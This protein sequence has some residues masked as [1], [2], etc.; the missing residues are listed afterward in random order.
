MK[1][2]EAYKRYLKVVNILKEE[3]K[4]KILKLVHELVNKSVNY[5]DYVVRA[6]IRIEQIKYRLEGE[7]FRRELENIDKN[8]RLLHNALMSQLMIVNRTL[9]KDGDI[10][11]KIP[12]GGMFSGNVDALARKDRDAV[13][14]WAG[15]L[16]KGL[17]KH[18][19]LRD[20]KITY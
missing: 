16:V 2:E 11:D 9:F 17:R 6:E 19:I 12:I 7:D 3:N 1:E 13:A 10:K 5:F 15:Y 14:N 18:G 4:K 8:R 20:S